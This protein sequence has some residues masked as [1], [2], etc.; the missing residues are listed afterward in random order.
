[1][2]VCRLNLSQHCRPR[3]GTCQK[4]ER[5]IP[6]PVLDV[7]GLVPGAAQGA[8]L[9]NRFLDDLR[10]AK[11]FIHVVDASGTTDAEG[12][13]TSGYDPTQDIA[14]LLSEIQAWIRGNLQQKWSAFK[15][16]AST[17]MAL[18]SV[19]QRYLAGYGADKKMCSKVASLMPAA[20]LKKPIESW[21]EPEL[22]LLVETFVRERFPMVIVRS[23]CSST[24]KDAFLFFFRDSTKLICPN[25]INTFPTFAL[26]TPI[27]PETIVSLS[28][29]RLLRT[30]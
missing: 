20:L 19:L 13:E 4:G 27:W 29:P 16:K 9:G 17:G 28:C 5:A 6:V 7:A 3:Y 30:S 24:L 2:L 12:K 23:S 14:W 22:D 21:D 8:G 26:P 11:T 18:H 25:R 10:Q 15:R 1:M